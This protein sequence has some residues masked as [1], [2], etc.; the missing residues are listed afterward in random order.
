M[1]L[2][3][4]LIGM[5]VWQRVCGAKESDFEWVAVDGGEDRACRG[6]NAGDN[7]AEYFNVSSAPRLRRMLTGTALLRL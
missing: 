4:D 1:I 6:A 5:A 3:I 2:H 7:R